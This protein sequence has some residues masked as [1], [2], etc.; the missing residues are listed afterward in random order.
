MS[1]DYRVDIQEENKAIKE[2]SVLEEVLE[3][4]YT[5]I[6]DIYNQYDSGKITKKQATDIII[7]I[8]G[9]D[10]YDFIVKQIVI[11]GDK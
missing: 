6:N 3:E 11:E 9:K 10:R 1:T 8:V 7:N 5:S 4:L 2:D